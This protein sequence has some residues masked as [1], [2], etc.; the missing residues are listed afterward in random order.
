MN[1]L[2]GLLSFARSLLVGTPDV[3]TAKWFASVFTIVSSLLGFCCQRRDVVLTVTCW[4]VE[5]SEVENNMITLGTLLPSGFQAHLKVFSAM[6][7][8]TFG[9]DVSGTIS[10]ES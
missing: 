9:F 7:F 1:R 8:L 4:S 2:Q 6:K 3:C 10:S 5:P